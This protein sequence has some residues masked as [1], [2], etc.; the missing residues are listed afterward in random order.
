MQALFSG[1]MRVLF[2]VAGCSISASAPAQ[3]AREWQLERNKNGIEVY[4][5]NQTH[6]QVKSVISINAPLSGMVALIK[7]DQAATQWIDRMSAFENIR[8]V[9]DQ[10]WYTYGEIA[11]PW[12]FKNRDVISRNQISQDAETGDVVITIVSVPDYMAEKPGKSRIGQ[13]EASWTFR[14]GPDG[15]LTVTYVADAPAEDLPAWPA[16]TDRKCL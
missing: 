14:P 7:D 15:T 6:L 11:I 9:N 13:S 5:R 10:E 12:P 4:T 2:L 8:T 1:C 16:G 3:S